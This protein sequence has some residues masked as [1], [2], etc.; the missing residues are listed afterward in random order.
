MRRL[1]GF[2]LLLS[3]CHREPAPA[4]AP[5]QAYREFAQ[6]VAD[7][8]QGKDPKSLLGYFDAPTRAALTARAD[9]AA[10]ASGDD[11]LK[12]PGG[13][14]LLGGPGAPPLAD[15]KVLAEQG[16]AATLQVSTDAG[17]AS[18]VK[19]VR[20]EGRWRIHLDAVPGG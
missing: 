6:A 5:D 1:L 13:S 8:H 14:M 17:P 20:E 12:E 15:V 4:A 16:D 18:T 19:M 10:K 9:A 2:A 7:A 11:S 3:A